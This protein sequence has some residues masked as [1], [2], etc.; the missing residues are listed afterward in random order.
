[1]IVNLILF[2][3]KVDEMVRESSVI[4]RYIDWLQ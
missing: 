4:W 1:M 2:H 3:P